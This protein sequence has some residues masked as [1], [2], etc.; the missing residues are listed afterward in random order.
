MRIGRIHHVWR[1]IV[2]EI[3]P[4]LFVSIVDHGL[5][6]VVA[7]DHVEAA[8]VQKM[9]VQKEHPLVRVALERDKCAAS[10]TVLLAELDDARVFK[11]FERIMSGQLKYRLFC[12][13]KILT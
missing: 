8:Y 9:L 5:R 10:K 1:I 6:V 11:L 2:Y 3:E 13:A 7:V 4:V 12:G